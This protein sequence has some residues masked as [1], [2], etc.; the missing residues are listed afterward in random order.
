MVIMWW[1]VAGL[2]SLLLSGLE[3][4]SFQGFSPRTDH[5][6]SLFNFIRPLLK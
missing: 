1:V 4:K 2:L 5:S 3:A 6:F